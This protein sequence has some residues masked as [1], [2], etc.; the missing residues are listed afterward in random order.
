MINSQCQ[1]IDIIDVITTEPAGIIANVC[2][3][4]GKVALLVHIGIK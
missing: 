3:N 1:V 4:P 2:E